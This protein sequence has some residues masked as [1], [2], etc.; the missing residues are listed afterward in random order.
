MFFNSERAVFESIITALWT[1]SNTSF[2]H[3]NAIV[4]L[5]AEE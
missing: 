4:P 5:F 2:D 1:L 3:D